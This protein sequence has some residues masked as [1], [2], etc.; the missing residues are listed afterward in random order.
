MS[1]AAK[2]TCSSRKYL[3]CTPKNWSSPHALYFDHIQYVQ[4]QIQ[5]EEKGINLTHF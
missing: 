3:K 5:L 4:S 1:E 2:T